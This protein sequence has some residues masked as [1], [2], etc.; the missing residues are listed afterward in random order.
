MG[1]SNEI[2]SGNFS[3][4][5]ALRTAFCER[6][7][8]MPTLCMTTNRAKDKKV[9]KKAT[10]INVFKHRELSTVASGNRELLTNSGLKP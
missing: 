3:P 1:I 6:N 8:C 9:W 2:T 5:L 7:M 4:I 10:E